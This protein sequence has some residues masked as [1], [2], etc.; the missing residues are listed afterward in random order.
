MIFIR[1]HSREFAAL[2]Q[3]ARSRIRCG[4]IL[5]AR[6]PLETIGP[7]GGKLRF[8]FSLWMQGLPLD[9]LPAE[10]WLNLDTAR[11]GDWAVGAD[12]DPVRRGVVR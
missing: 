11:F 4:S 2:L 12:E 10:G 7:R 8:Q 6:V 9:A 1:V 3:A 5:E